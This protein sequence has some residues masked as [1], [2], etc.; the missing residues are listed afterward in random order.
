MVT[1]AG[2]EGRHTSRCPRSLY[3]AAPAE[4]LGRHRRKSPPA[5][6]ALEPKAHARLHASCLS[7]TA[8]LSQAG[9]VVFAHDARHAHVRDLSYSSTITESA[10]TLTGP[11]QAGAH[12]Q[13]ANKPVRSRAMRQLALFRSLWT[14]WRSWRYVRPLA[15]SSATRLAR[16]LPGTGLPSGVRLPMSPVRLQAQRHSAREA[17]LYTG[18]H[19]E[20]YVLSAAC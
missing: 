16:P 8:H 10:A 19:V 9:E 17:A 3:T 7:T 20:L 5:Q 18:Q 14:T 4:F 13:L 2:S 15:M 12:R 1:R 6:Q 11:S